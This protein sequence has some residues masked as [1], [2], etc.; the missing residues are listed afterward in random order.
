MNIPTPPENCTA[1]RR[2]T[3]EYDPDNLTPEQAAE[4]LVRLSQ[5]LGLYED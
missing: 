1:C 3:V 2:E 5:E 4:E